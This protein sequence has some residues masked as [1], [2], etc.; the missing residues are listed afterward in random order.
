MLYSE[1]PKMKKI[2]IED[3]VFWILIIVIVTIIIWILSGSPPLENSLPS[4]IAFLLASEL[5]I[6]KA[7]F[8]MDKKTAVG[9]MKIRND[10]NNKFNEINHRL[11]NIESLIK[12]KK[13][14][15]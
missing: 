1:Q 10:L 15:M 11:K 6:W 8:N 7:H 14:Q 4:L 13:W 12:G 9:F 3:I 2:K 5:L